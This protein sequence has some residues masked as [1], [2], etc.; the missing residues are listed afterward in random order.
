MKSIKQPVIGS[1]RSDLSALKRLLPQLQQIVY[2]EGKILAEDGWV[3][4]RS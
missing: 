4:L 1:K 3:S 2:P